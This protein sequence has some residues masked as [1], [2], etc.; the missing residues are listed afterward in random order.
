MRGVTDRS[1]ARGAGRGSWAPTAV[2]LA[3]VSCSEPAV[4][5]KP[6]DG[7][8]LVV[9]DTLRADR[10][11][12]YGGDVPTPN[13]DALAARGVR[14]KDAR[15]QGGHT[16][17][18]MISL[19]SG[20]WVTEHS[21]ALPKDSPTIAEVFDRAG[22]HT[23]AFVANPVCSRGRGFARGFD[24]FAEFDGQALHSDVLAQSF[25]AWLDTH[26]VH[27]DE[28][29]F[30]W[31][32][33]MDPHA[34]YT[35]RD[36]D[37]AAVDEPLASAEQLAV[38]RTTLARFETQVGALPSEVF[39]RS[40]ADML[41]TRR[42]YDAEV[43]AFDAALGELLTALDDRDERENTLIVF[44]S[45]HGEQLFEVPLE[46]GDFTAVAAGWRE[47]QG[48]EALHQLGHQDWFH[49][50]V[51][52]T[53]LVIAGPGFEGGRV[54]TG[55][56]ANLDIAPTLFAS[57]AV[58]APSTIEG[59]D[60]RGLDHVDREHVFAFG[61][62]SRAVRSSAGAQWT[63]LPRSMTLLGDDEPSGFLEDEARAGFA[64]ARDAERRETIDSLTRAIAEWRAQSRFVPNFDVDV[65]E[66]ATLERLGYSV[67]D[68]RREGDH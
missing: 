6:L 54:A 68:R 33:A 63:E 34:P 8:L 43:L 3:L 22:F 13:I 66:T 52:H 62:D 9:C 18:S 2:L 49:R 38:W 57:A 23:G 41:A 36:A 48:L 61:Q 37:L 32:H 27:D 14:F 19:M 47:K 12:C 28:P 42:A 53:P 5:T 17:P 59:R 24:S 30:A 64:A 67:P 21:D 44:A 4:R 29:W 15:S 16:L 46:P 50:E 7:V 58:S 1:K 11:G 10:L 55:L 39:D 65:S 40:V 56:A 51:W 26:E 35:P 25:S 31:V 60:L 20:T 45:D